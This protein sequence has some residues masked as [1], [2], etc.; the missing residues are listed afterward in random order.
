MDGF[1]GGGGGDVAL[2]SKTTIV[3]E[4]CT[5]TLLMNANLEW[6]LKNERGGM[7]DLH[8]SNQQE[9]ILLDKKL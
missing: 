6:D 4:E 2:G 9:F 5:V 7:F 8:A 3:V 1:F